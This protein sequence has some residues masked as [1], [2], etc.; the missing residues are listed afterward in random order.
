MGVQTVGQPP[1]VT[2][3]SIS[4]HTAPQ[5]VNFCLLFPAV[6]R[7]GSVFAAPE[8]WAVVMLKDI[9]QDLEESDSEDGMYCRLREFGHGVDLFQPDSGVNGNGIR[10]IDPSEGGELR[11]DEDQAR[12]APQEG[13]SGCLPF[14]DR[15]SVV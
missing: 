7:R 13:H 8:N 4:Y 1:Y 14:S 10:G 3:P 15:K 6:L 11:G 2:A 9:F 12:H 5:F